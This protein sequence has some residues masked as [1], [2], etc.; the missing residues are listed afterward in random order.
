M[1]F[2]GAIEKAIGKKA[3]KEFLPLQPGDVPVTYADVDDLIKDTGFKPSTSVV[4]GIQYF[5]DWYKEYYK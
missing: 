2:V 1:E 3:K 4:E 5:I